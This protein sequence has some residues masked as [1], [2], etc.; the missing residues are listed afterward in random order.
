MQ[1]VVINKNLDRFF[2]NKK[3]QLHR[4]N[5]PAIEYSNGDRVWYQNDKRHRIDGPAVEYENG[6]KSWWVNG[7]AFSEKEFSRI[8][9]K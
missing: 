1:T 6:Y 8:V 9:K 3:F 5:G 4:D 7:V 2:Y